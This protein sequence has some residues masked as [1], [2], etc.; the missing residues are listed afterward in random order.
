MPNMLVIVLTS[1]LQI[2]LCIKLLFAS[3]GALCT[4]VIHTFPQVPELQLW[5]GIR[6][7]GS[8][9]Q[10]KLSTARGFRGSSR[11]LEL[12]ISQNGLFSDLLAS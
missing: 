6:G 9:F 11:F 3:S 4:H 2:M 7:C 10:S 8:P 12:K 5:G 1:A